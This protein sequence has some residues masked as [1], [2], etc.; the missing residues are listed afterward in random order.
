MKIIVVGGGEIGSRL[1]KFLSDKKHDVVLVERDEKLCQELADRL[2][3]KVIHGDGTRSDVLEEA[4]IK[5]ADVLVVAT[6]EDETNLLVCLVAKEVL[7]EGSKLKASKDEYKK[8]FLKIGVDNIVSPET[9]TIEQL[10]DIIEPEISD[11]GKLYKSMLNLV[12]FEVG[13]KS[14]VIKKPANRVEFPEESLVIA[15]KRKDQFIIPGENEKFEA[16]DK[17]IMVLKKTMQ[18]RIEEMFKP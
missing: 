2:N 9:S 13:K 8:I 11:L 16:G 18:S 14:E 1:T 15:I 5:K 6:R 17:V 4:G 10:E 3:I 7:K 12:E